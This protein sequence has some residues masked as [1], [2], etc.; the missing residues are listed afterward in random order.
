MKS[1]II[2][3]KH[4]S[5][6]KHEILN[7]IFTETDDFLL[8]FLVGISLI[9]LS[10]TYSINLAYSQN[11]TEN[12]TN[13]VSRYLNGPLSTYENS[14]IGFKIHYPSDCTVKQFGYIVILCDGIMISNVNLQTGQ[15]MGSL[16]EATKALSA[17]YNPKFSVTPITLNQGIPANK[18][19]EI[20]TGRITFV[21]VK[22]NTVF[23]IATESSNSNT[24]QLMERMIETFEITK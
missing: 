15:N 17:G 10:V 22:N 12:S 5:K 19:E 16:H 20:G 9:T 3:I 13:N 23:T 2:F 18:V 21:T 4:Y 14:T 6:S 11:A 1:S 7:F 8:L 24:D